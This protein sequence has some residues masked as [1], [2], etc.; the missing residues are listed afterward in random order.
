MLLVTAVCVGGAYLLGIPI[1]S[2]LYKIDLTPYRYELVMIMLGGGLNAMMTIFRFS[3]TAMR[4][5]NISLLA[6]VLSFIG[7]IVF[8]PY[9]VQHYAI[10]G[11][12]YSYLLSMLVMNIVF[13]FIIVF[14]V[15]KWMLNANTERMNSHESF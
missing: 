14:K 3:L 13:F 1:L 11:A 6:F 5:Q 12:C 9:L 8:T 7:A 15:R 2:L 4:E 10:R